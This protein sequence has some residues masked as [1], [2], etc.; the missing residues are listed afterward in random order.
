MRL[1]NVWQNIWRSATVRERVAAG[2]D[3]VLTQGFVAS[4]ARGETCV[5]GRGGS[6]TSAALF[7][8]RLDAT[9]CT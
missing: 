6:D 3:V 4:N 1:S 9:N 5:L 7:A 2:A 8:R